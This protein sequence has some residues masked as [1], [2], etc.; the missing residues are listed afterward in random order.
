M[1]CE[2]TLTVNSNG[3]HRI[4]PLGKS[5]TPLTSFNDVRKILRKMSSVELDEILNSL[6]SIEEI[7]NIDIADISENSV[8]VFTPA[9]LIS[10]LPKAYKDTLYKLNIDRDTFKSNIVIAGFGDSNEK[11]QFVNGHIFLNL[12]YLYDDDNK[13]MAVFESALYLSSPEN[14]ESNVSILLDE[15]VSSEDKLAIIKK[16]FKLGANDNDFNIIKS[17]YDFT[18]IKRAGAEPVSLDLI[19][20]RSNKENFFW[21]FDTSV[22]KDPKEREQN[23]APREI[24]RIESLRQGDLVG[25]T[26]DD[27]SKTKTGKPNLKT[28][29]E[30]FY[31]YFVDQNGNTVLHTRAES[32]TDFEKRLITSDK[33]L[34][35]RFAPDAY[36]NFSSRLEGVVVP[37]TDKLTETKYKYTY[38]LIR[39]YGVA[40]S[41]YSID[42]ETKKKTSVVNVKIN[43]LQGSEIILEDGRSI[44]ITDLTSVT[45]NKKNVSF[46]QFSEIG[47]IPN[48]LDIT[49]KLKS[50]PVNTTIIL[51]DTIDGKTIFKE[52]V[53]IAKGKHTGMESEDLIYITSDKT[54]KNIVGRIITKNVQYILANP[55]SEVSITE[56]KELNEVIKQAYK[57]NSLNEFIAFKENR[58]LDFS[59]SSEKVN[60][61]TNYLVGD[62]LHDFNTGR[63]FKVLEV[64]NKGIILSSV[65]NDKIEYI[66]LS[67]E[68][69]SNSIK[70]SKSAINQ[71]F[72]IGQIIKNRYKIDTIANPDQI[73]GSKLEGIESIEILDIYQKENGFI[74]PLTVADN[75]ET[76]PLFDPKDKIITKYFKTLLSERFNKSIKD[77]DKLYVYRYKKTQGILHDENNTR[78]FDI[79]GKSVQNFSKYIIPGTYITF[80][81]NAKA[82]VVEQAIDGKFI[83]AAYHYTRSKN[84]EPKRELESVIGERF[85]WDS[86]AEFE[87]SPEPMALYVPRWATYNIKQIE[88][89]LIPVDNSTKLSAI[90]SYSKQDSPEVI[91]ALINFLSSK[92]NVTVNMI[93]NSELGDFPGADISRAAAFVYQGQIYVNIDKASIEEPLHELLHLVLMTLKAKNAD[94]YYTIIN[95][96]QSHPLFDKVAKVYSGDI[97]S[98]KLEETFVKL[99]SQ[100]FRNK[101]I[102]AGVFT[103]N[104][105]SDAMN[106]AVA[107]LFKLTLNT[108]G[109]D[110]FDLL[111]IPVNEVMSTF[112][113]ELLGAKDG[114][115]DTESVLTMLEISGTIKELVQN[116]NL[117]EECK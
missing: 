90:S 71:T 38:N 31:D 62:I 44:N 19:N 9:E 54:G 112:G 111:G 41:G 80:K 88:K 30:V 60:T 107:D 99:L 73:T 46:K 37:L 36:T 15:N 14:Y 43:R 10:D 101:V 45:T 82:F 75:K 65:F 22:Y 100:T 66:E 72:A 83:L 20:L 12:N 3:Q 96:I 7:S 55:L 104:A 115:I 29:F 57:S 97:N 59:Y 84:V 86:N 40:V 113:S 69:M 93:D 2:I 32:E 48:V 78:Y 28:K 64:S 34:A 13:V 103:S 21:L 17:V 52:A 116:N 5:E 98:E 70:F 108:K 11:T 74:Y 61:S 114:L 18:A 49:G 91:S 68:L 76:M 117:K 51:S 35:R 23:Y 53:V 4:I 26:Y 1:S 27:G 39:D 79:A 47:N 92:Y 89:V 67:D 109:V 85:M 6:P 102:N 77:S 87:D 106:E 8:G 56:K 50:I 105:F 63:Y 95:S 94:N 24:V 110:T 81:G 25:V 33:I 16:V 42:H 58:L